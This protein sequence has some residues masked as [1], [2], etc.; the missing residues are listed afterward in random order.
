MC[1]KKLVKICKTLGKYQQ[2]FLKEQN[3]K[4]KD[5]KGSKKIY[6]MCWRS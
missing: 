4:E 6:K 1:K 3:N 5:K 2:K